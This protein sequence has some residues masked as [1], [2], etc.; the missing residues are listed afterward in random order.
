MAQGVLITETLL[1]TAIQNIP[2]GGKEEGWCG[3]CVGVQEA[4]VSSW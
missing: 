2:V 1:L 3:T 4:H